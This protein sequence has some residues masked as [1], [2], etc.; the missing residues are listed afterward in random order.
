MVEFKYSNF[1]NEAKIK[2]HIHTDIDLIVRDCFIDYL[3]MT[4]LKINTNLIDQSD[5]DSS[6]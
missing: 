3:H 1:K 5:K 2:N 4:V 6:K